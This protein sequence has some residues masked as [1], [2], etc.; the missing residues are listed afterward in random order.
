[1]FDQIGG[2][3]KLV[4]GKT[5]A[6]KID[7]TNP[8]RDRTG[9]RP[10]WYTRWTHPDVIAAAVSL[11]GAA[12]AKRIRIL[13][14]STEDA[15]PLEENF[16]IGGWDPDKIL[17]AAKGV[18]MEN[19]AWNGYGQNYFTLKVPDKPYIYPGFEVNHSYV[20]CDVFVS[21]AKLK[22]HQEAGIAL[23]MTNMLGI[24]PPTIYGDSA[25]YEEPAAR[26]Y[27]ARSMFSTGR[28][29]PSPP[30]PPEVSEESPRDPGYRIPRI[31]VDLLRA[32]PIHLAIIDGIE[33]QTASEGVTVA[34]GS[35]R[36]IR[37]VKPGVLLAGFNPVCTDSVA[38][39]VMGFDPRAGRGTAPF[40]ACDS[41]L[42]LA[43]ESGVGTTDLGAIEVAGT[44]IRTVSMPFRAVS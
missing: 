31:V 34:A 38:A 18:E 15:H 26:P 23:S 12:G 41:M 36:Q 24:T 39:A 3:G 30:A 8:L 33:T 2:V 35:K 4:E 16:L 9:F 44:P 28:R 19:T 37:L 22:E 21:M 14:S 17:R 20:E 29:Q 43:E 1:M 42:R 5:V 10:A 27:G 7:M 13:E 40:D 32:R 25:G 11:F 6:I